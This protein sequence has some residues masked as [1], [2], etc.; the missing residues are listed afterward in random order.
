M[1]KEGFFESDLEEA[2][3]EWLEE[4]GYEVALGPDLID[5]TM[6]R[7]SHED[8]LLLGRLKSSLER[9]NPGKSSDLIDQA[10]REIAIPKQVSLLEN[11][12]AFHKML[13]DGIDVGFHDENGLMTYQKV[14]IF[15]FETPENNE[16][17]A[18]NQYTVVEN[19][20]NKRP[21]IVLLINGIPVVVIELKT[22]SD[23]KISI[24]S[25][26]NQIKNY[27]TSIPSLFVYNAF[28]ILSDGLH[29]Q[30]GTLTSG[31]DRYM[32][33]RTIDG[34]TVAPISE[35]QLETLIKGM[36]DQKRLLDIIQHFILFQDNENKFVKIISGYHQYHAVNTA[37]N[38][39]YQATSEQGDRRIGVIWHTQGSGKS[40]SMVFYAGKMVISK[41]LN[42]P[43]ILVITDRNDLDDQ[44]YQTFAK[45]ESL[46]RSIPQQAS[47]RTHLRELLNGR[48]SGGIIF[49]T[50]QK[51]SPDEDHD[52]T[53]LTTRK[54]VIVM[55]DE[56]HRSQYGFSANIVQKE[57][58]AYEKYGFAK[59][60]RDSLPNA[61]YIGFT[62]TPIELTDK[63][64]RAVFG[65]YIDVYDM[66]RAVEDKTT[67]KIFY[68][69][70]IAKIDFKIPKEKIDEDFIEITENEEAEANNDIKRKWS[71]LEAIVGTPARINLIAQDI[72]D[73]F[74][75]R[76]MAMETPVGKAMIVAMSRRIAVELYEV[77]VK[78]RP[79]WHSDDL[80]KGK[81]KVVMTG[82]SSDPEHWQP[83]IGNKQTRETLAKRM[84][85][86]TDE[87]EIAIVRDM[88]LTG[89]DVPSLHTM[90]IDKPMRGHGLM[91]SIA[92]V[93][94]VF[95]KKQGGLVVDYI[96]IA[97]KLKEALSAYSERDKGS[98]GVDTDQAVQILLEKLS[99]IQDTLHP[100][101]YSP[102]FTGTKSEKL[103]T[104]V[105]T[106]NYIVGLN[107]KERKDLNHTIDDVSKAYGLCATT[108]E[109]LEVNEEVGFYKAVKATAS[110]FT[111]TGDPRRTDSD[112]NDQINQLVAESFKSAGMIDVM[113]S[114]GNERPELS[115]LSEDFLAQ[116]K[117]SK[118]KN[119]SVELLKRL[120]KGNLR[121]VARRTV[122][123]SK[124]FSDLLESTMEK[125]YNQLLSSAE[126]IDELIKLA[127]DIIKAEDEGKDSGLST[128]E[129]AFYEALSSNRSA[130]EVMGTEVL[131]DIAKE[132]TQ[133]IQDS[134]TVDWERRKNIRAKMRFEIKLLLKKFKYPPD[135]PD[136]PGNYDNSIKLIME[137]TELFSQ[138]SLNNR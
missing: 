16:F 98:A 23:D 52:S 11:N 134:I 15:D 136:K 89:F 41:T 35:P 75:K 44:L 4:L 99:I 6:E 92:R 74:E 93:N 133:K 28:N 122:V 33:W 61:S 102:Y 84:K 129:Y 42:N 57:S 117:A 94:R 120:I 130:M 36:L 105:S 116:I 108:D 123:K 125:Y 18:V 51:F 45:S 22:I 101:D 132:L 72:V 48:E 112:V 26:Y 88:W 10:Y 37:L 67:V 5:I 59:Y 24:D 2:A 69:S 31:R 14:R 137:Q 66:T 127:K 70:R 29:A 86:N 7:K 47:S 25:A 131:K 3:L 27:Q 20:V 65:E 82:S 79:A 115:I 1:R 62:G 113:E 90:Y 135:D 126:I 91:Q 128:E 21:D 30:A 60:M 83:H 58:E 68:E 73:H 43:T 85:D 103:K 80:N 40:I 107:Q 100:H 17:L 87:L 110:K 119:L 81:I 97:S 53:P 55:A 106:A 138:E 54:N 64:T 76:Q 8:V 78:L 118:H 114:M 19:G 63:N 96:G 46:L 95:G 124:Q 32:A 13:T 9:L 12:Q 56:A 77:I 104:I 39:T 38:K 111:D 34:E 50:I 71:R 121:R 109:A 49:T